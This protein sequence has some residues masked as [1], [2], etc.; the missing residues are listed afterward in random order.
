MLPWLVGSAFYRQE[1]Q[2]DG[3]IH[4]AE[5]NA[6]PQGAEAFARQAFAAVSHD[7]RDQIGQV[8]VPSLVVVGEL[9]LVNPPR[10]A[11][12]LANRLREARHGRDAGGRPHAP[13]RGPD[14]PADGDRTVSESKVCLTPAKSRLF[15]R[16]DQENIGMRLPG[17]VAC[18]LHPT[19]LPGRH[20]IGDLG[21]EAHAFVDFL[22]AA[23]QRWWQILPLGPTGYGNSPYQ[24]HSSF[25][26][27]PLLID[28]DNLVETGMA[29]SS[30][31]P[32][33][34]RSCRRTRSI[35]MRSPFQGR[36]RCGWH[37]RDSRRGVR[38][39]FRRI[40]SAPTVS[41]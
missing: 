6:W 41:G 33:R 21:S 4:F 37:T 22:A 28:L 32:A 26:G 9:D 5:R 23:G 1:A 14:G 3:L 36:G 38:P 30:S 31:V 15:K 13:R 19:S 27:N 18:L 8:R 11:S 7:T 20:G 35:T 34:S 25:A 12:E 10:V 39:A 40:H 16:Y 2:I 17:Q 29:R 24:S